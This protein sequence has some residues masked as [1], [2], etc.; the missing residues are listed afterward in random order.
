MKEKQQKREEIY[1]KYLLDIRKKLNKYKQNEI[2]AVHYNNPTIKEIEKM[3]QEYHPRI[4]ER[5]VNDD[6]FLMLSIGTACLLYTSR[7]V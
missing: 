1:E 6:D 4:Y 7:C 3:V 5:D 2:E